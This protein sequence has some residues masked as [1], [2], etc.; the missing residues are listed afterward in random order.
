MKNSKITYIDFGQPG[1]KIV[2][3]IGCRAT[4]IHHLKI[5][6]LSPSCTVYIK[7]SRTNVTFLL[8]AGIRVLIDRHDLFALPMHSLSQVFD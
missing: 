5:L 3:D 7:I 4:L 6:I 1:V 8:E 2:P